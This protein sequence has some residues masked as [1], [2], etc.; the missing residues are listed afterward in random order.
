MVSSET[1]Q[2]INE[3][4]NRFQTP[5][6]NK[7]TLSKAQARVNQSTEGALSYV[8]GNDKPDEETIAT[9]I[10]LMRKYRAAGN[11]QLEADIAGNL[12]EKLTKAGRTVQ[13]ASIF[14][15]LSPDGVLVYAQR[16]IQKAQSK[17][18]GKLK[19]VE[20]TIE[21]LL[22]KL[23]KANQDVSDQVVEEIRKELPDLAKLGKPKLNP[24]KPRANDAEFKA[25]FDRIAAEDSTDKAASTLAG[26]IAPTQ[27]TRKPDPLKE[28][29]NELYRIALS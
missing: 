10:E 1:K 23:G 6:T 4:P 19:K 13:A 16:Q 28:M 15:R 12:A 26:K 14:N 8:M 29:V 7:E 22:P 21:D 25:L 17:S 5:I 3:L 11:T 24:P 9:G 2:A 18:P 20:K 27:K